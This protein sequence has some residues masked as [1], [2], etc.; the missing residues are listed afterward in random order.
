MAQFWLRRRRNRAS[1][2]VGAERPEG[3][4]PVPLSLQ[5]AMPGGESAGL[6]ARG[7][8]PSCRGGRGGSGVCR[9]DGATAL[10]GT[11]YRRL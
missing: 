3:P 4:L 7:A 10:L 8:G 5:D 6:R 11:T 9:D 1:L 2:W